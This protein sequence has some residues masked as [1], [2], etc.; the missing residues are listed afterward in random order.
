MIVLATFLSS[1]YFFSLCQSPFLFKS[2]YHIFQNILIFWLF[3]SRLYHVKLWNKCSIW[4]LFVVTS[5]AVFNL[6]NFISLIFSFILQTSFFKIILKLIYKI[7]NFG[8]RK[9]N[10]NS[11]H[12][13]EKLRSTFTGL[14]AMI[15]RRRLNSFL[16][17]AWRWH[18]FSIDIHCYLWLLAYLRVVDHRLILM[19][20]YWN[21]LVLNS[22]V[23]LIRNLGCWF[24]ADAWNH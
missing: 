20:L 6:C 5:L 23:W 9:F 1:A 19:N 2:W 22:N 10:L 21:W 11:Q 16:W 12:L 13:L 24:Q 17:G 4:H 18:N 15:I 3:L 8:R 14:H 7:N